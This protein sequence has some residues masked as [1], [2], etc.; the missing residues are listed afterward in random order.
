V[1]AGLP[2]INTLQDLIKTGDEVDKVEGVVSG[3]LSFLFNELA[4]GRLFSEII[5]EAKKLG[6][7]EPDPREDLSGM[8]VARKFICL[9]REIGYDISFND[10]KLHNLVPE[11]L[12]SCSVD[13]FLAKLPEYDN[14][15]ADLVKQSKNKQ[16]Q[17]CYMGVIHPDGKIDVDIHSLPDTHAFSRL[18]G[19][20]NMLI[21]HT[22]R[23]HEQPLIIQ[24]PG[25]GA[26]VT[27]AGI[28]ADLL[29]LVSFIS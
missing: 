8:D 10:I 16:E 12:R 7:T 11:T 20:D 14:E 1:C 22:R 24:G 4:K 23:Y 2:I 26:E 25:A 15:I 19:A 18:R 17:L 28:F 13:E 6:F 29:R 5:F 21:F 3:T 27:A 9:A